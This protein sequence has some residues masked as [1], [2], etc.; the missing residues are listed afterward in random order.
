MA[1]VLV[2]DDTDIL[3]AALVQVLRRMGH[4]PVPASDGLTALDLARQAPPDLALLDLRMP[5]MD[6]AELFQA[7]R[8]S[9]G[10][11]CPRVIFVSATP[12]DEVARRVESI[13]R[14][15]GYVKKPFSLD[16][17]MSKI[18]AALAE[19]H[20]GRVTATGA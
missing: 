12:P 1:R 20:A 19:G 7:L 5:G 4:T 15:V 18:A 8:A 10:E 11:R 14:P 3:R 13:G 6:G 2:V 17:L 9:L 16:E